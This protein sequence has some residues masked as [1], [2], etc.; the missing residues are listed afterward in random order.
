[1]GEKSDVCSHLVVEVG[2]TWLESR[3]PTHGSTGITQK[4][5]VAGRNLSTGESLM[6]VSV[7]G[8]LL[9]QRFK[10]ERQSLRRRLYIHLRTLRDAEVGNG[11]KRALQ[12]E[13]AALECAVEALGMVERRSIDQAEARFEAEV[14]EAEATCRRVAREEQAEALEH[15]LEWAK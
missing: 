6:T 2:I 5:L 11:S 4:H 9:L 13:I 8:S 3:R 15:T 7:N 14:R 1:M 12:D 10:E